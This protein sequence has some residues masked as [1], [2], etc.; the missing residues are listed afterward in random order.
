[1]YQWVPKINSPEDLKKVPREKLPEVAKEYRKLLIETVAKTGGH[2]GTSL[3]ALELNIAL[4]YVFAS[5][6][7]KI[8]WDVGH[9]AYVHK[10]I[11]GRKDR[12]STLRQYG[13]ISGFPSPEES[14][15]D[16]FIVAHA[17]TAISQALGLAIARDHKGGNEK[18][19]A[20]VGDGSLTSGLA[21][22]ALNNAGHLR[23]EMLVILNDNEWSI[24]KNVG[25][26]SKYLNKIITNPLYNR[27]RGEVE[28]QLD[29]FPRLRR[30][31]TASLESMKHLLVPGILF[32]ELGFRYFGPIDGHDIIGLVDTLSK[33]KKI[34]ELCFLHI[35][36]QKGKGVE[37]AEKDAERLHGVTPFDVKTG[38][39]IKTPEEEA[40]SKLE[41]ISYTK[42]FVKSL[43]QL[44]HEDRRIVAITAAM[45]SGTGLADFQ[46]EFPDRFFD[47]GIAEQHAI[48]FAGGL[49]K[50][51]LKPVCAIYSTFL[52]RSQDQLIHDV[53]L[54]KLGIVIAMDRAGLVGA[55]GAT[56]NGVFDI[57]YLGHIPGT[58]IAAP[59][60]EAEILQ[61]LKIGLN[62]P[63]IFALRYP[64]GN[65]PKFYEQFPVKEFGVGEG[66]ILREGSDVALLA[67]GSMIEVAYRAAQILAQEGVEAR[68]ASLRF[69]QPLD[70]K[71]LLETAKKTRFLF[72]LEE[73]NL[74]GGLGTKVLEFFERQESSQEV[75]IHRF[76]LPDQFIEHG[77][78]EL[79]LDH[80]GLSAEKVA[81]QVLHRIKAPSTRLAITE[82]LA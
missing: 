19:I 38:A 31:A 15:H 79:L 29:R 62:Y 42:A 53:A 78:R 57:S 3:G 32:E 6:K 82:E 17:G 59:R 66:E 23:P 11:T 50:G 16:H 52:Q 61:M 64:R 10:M 13:G 72:T 71:L 30:F 45:P 28:R 43:I 77:S 26:I 74:T 48:T 27:I 21:Y 18:I 54:Q 69:A 70:E 75:T 51:G 73:H 22:E 60:D 63:G 8:C 35:L 20:V 25:A 37:W 40:K 47:V 7:D 41:G 12:M 36:T 68:V 34:K 55:D 24:S 65:V 58:A 81:N 67:L 4:H 2:L 46:K 49:A 56:H 14:P 9:Q 39:K 76:A 80:F 44:A 1:M 33:I 5:P